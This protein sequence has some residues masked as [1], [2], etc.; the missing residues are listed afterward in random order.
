MCGCVQMTPALN[1]H[2]VDYKF[3]WHLTFTGNVNIR[4]T[5]EDSGRTEG[6]EKCLGLNTQV[7]AS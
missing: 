7:D 6:I 5:N 2:S 4:F 3:A 1:I